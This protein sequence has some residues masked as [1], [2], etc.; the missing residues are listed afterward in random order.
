[1][2]TAIKR[3]FPVAMFMMVA[4]CVP[5]LALAAVQIPVNHPEFCSVLDDDVDSDCGHRSYHRECYRMDRSYAPGELGGSYCC[6]SDCCRFR[7]LPCWPFRA[8]LRRFAGGVPPAVSD[9]RKR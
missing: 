4:L 2:N 8:E 1:M 7:V 5:E 9:G 6:R 3:F